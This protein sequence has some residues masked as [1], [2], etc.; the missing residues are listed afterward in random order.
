MSLEDVFMVLSVVLGLV[1]SYSTVYNR[2]RLE[3]PTYGIWTTILLDIV[4]ATKDN[5]ILPLIVIPQYGIYR[6]LDEMEHSRNLPS[7]G[8]TS[9]A[10]IPE[11]KAVGV[12]VD[13]ALV[14]GHVSSRDTAQPIK[15]LLKKFTWKSMPFRQ[16]RLLSAAVPLIVESKRLPTRHAKDV[17]QLVKD[18]SKILLEGVTQADYQVHCL[19]SNPRFALQQSVIVI[20]TAGPWW[21]W[22]EV[23]RT[24]VDDAP[25]TFEDYKSALKKGKQRAKRAEAA[26]NWQSDDDSGDNEPSQSAAPNTDTVDPAEEAEEADLL[27]LVEPSSAIQSFRRHVRTRTER[28]AEALRLEKVA[29]EK[30]KE[31]L[32]HGRAT[33]HQKLEAARELSAEL[34]SGLEEVLP[35][36]RAALNQAG[37]MVSRDLSGET[38]VMNYFAT[39]K[40]LFLATLDEHPPINHWSGIL[41][42]GTRES[43]AHLDSIKS[44]LKKVVVDTETEMKKFWDSI[45]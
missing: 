26:T 22:K 29:T 7:D 17:R 11:S 28:E 27:P 32:K 38:Q 25:F 3:N 6:T 30:R 13:F 2:R 20:V 9:M 41:H 1:V 15:K 21:C 44:R 5:S 23:N 43:N 35:Y 36:S 37:A 31:E 39:S 18:L 8:D 33:R 45:S 14:Y 12:E 42:V 19:F 4:Y 16:I 34:T 40:H 24:D 10:T